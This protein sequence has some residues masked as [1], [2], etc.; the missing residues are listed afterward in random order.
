MEEGVVAVLGTFV[1]SESVVAL[2]DEEAVVAVIG[3]SCTVL[4]TSLAEVTVV[5][6]SRVLRVNVPQDPGPLL[7]RSLFVYSSAT[8]KRTYGNR[9]AT[10]R[11]VHKAFRIGTNVA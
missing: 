3:S 11:L 1:G 4:V 9:F 7:R 2:R 5:S 6:F 8:K 10:H